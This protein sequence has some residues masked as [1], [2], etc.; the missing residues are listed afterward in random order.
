MK[1]IWIILALLYLISPYDII[2]GLHLPAWIDDIVVMGLLIRYLQKL[3]SQTAA[4]GPHQSDRQSDHQQPEEDG[5]TSDA[6]NRTP[7]EVLG[8]STDADQKEIQAAYRKLANQ[9]HPD[10]VAH[11]GEEFNAMAEQRFKEI[12]KAYDEL[13]R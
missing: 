9:Y 4:K 10:K 13:K 8:I 7:H 12:Q 11:L 6:Q 2:S 1:W 3:R 5:N